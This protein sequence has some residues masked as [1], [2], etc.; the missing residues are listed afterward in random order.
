[1]AN[2]GQCSNNMKQLGLAIHAYHTT[3]GFIPRTEFEI[4]CQT[5]YPYW[6]W[7]PRLLAYLE[8]NDLAVY[9]N[10]NDSPACASVLPLRKAVIQTFV[11]PSD[12]HR[13]SNQSYRDYGIQSGTPGRGCYCAPS[14]GQDCSV[15]PGTE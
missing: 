11:C 7:L 14:W 6:G 15:S 13:T 4:G 3:H 9:V 10:T 2:R 5:G 12:P 1:A 8:R